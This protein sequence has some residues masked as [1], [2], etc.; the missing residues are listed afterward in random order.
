MIGFARWC[1]DVGVSPDEVT[2][3]TL[4]DYSEFRLTPTIRTGLV[5]LRS[6]I[7]QNCKRALRMGLRGSAT[8]VLTAP[9]HPHV[10]ALPLGCFPISFQTEL[11]G[12]LSKRTDPDA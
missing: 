7:R 1:S 12:Y 3:Q 11:A 9:T 4:E 10:E 5:A 6:S 8:R 2:E